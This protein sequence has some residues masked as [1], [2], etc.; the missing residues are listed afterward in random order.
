[1]SLL[2]LADFELPSMAGLPGIADASRSTRRAACESEAAPAECRCERALQLQAS[3][4]TVLRHTHTISQKLRSLQAASPETDVATTQ[5]A[6]LDLP[7][8]V[9]ARISS[10]ETVALQQ[11]VRDLTAELLVERLH[12]KRANSLNQHLHELWWT[13][14]SA[15]GR[16]GSAVEPP[17]AL[18]D[19]LGRD[20]EFYRDAALQA[21]S[22]Q[23]AA[24]SRSRHLCA[25]IQALSDELART[26]AGSAAADALELSARTSRSVAM[27][28]TQSPREIFSRARVGRAAAGLRSDG[29][30][31][32]TLSSASS[33]DFLAPVSP[34]R[35]PLESP[36]HPRAKQ[37]PPRDGRSTEKVRNPAAPFGPAAELSSA[38]CIRGSVAAASSPS[39][40]VPR[41]RAELLMLSAE[42]ATAQ[43]R[44][45]ELAQQLESASHVV[46]LLAPR[47]FYYVGDAAVDINKPASQAA[48]PG[49]AFAID[50]RV[51]EDATARGLRVPLDGGGDGLKRS[52]AKDLLGGGRAAGAGL[53]PV[54][55]LHHIVRD[56]RMQIAAQA[57]Q[58]QAT[59]VTLQRARAVVLRK[60]LRRIF[61]RSADCSR[62]AVIAAEVDGASDTASLSPAALGAMGSPCVD[63][64]T[65]GALR[66]ALE[67]WRAAAF[68]RAVE[69][70]TARAASA[71]TAA[72][73]QLLLQRSLLRW[74]YA[75]RRRQQAVRLLGRRLH[76]R[77]L[78]LAWQVWKGRT[79]DAAERATELDNGECVT[80]LTATRG[81][82]Y[83]AL[84]AA[85][86]DLP[87]EPCWTRGD[88][89]SEPVAGSPRVHP[90]RPL[91]IGERKPHLSV[92]PSRA[93][94][95][96][97]L[98]ASLQAQAGLRLQVEAATAETSR[99][100]A[101]LQ[102]TDAAV[103][104]SAAALALLQA[105]VG[106]LQ[107]QLRDSK[108]QTRMA[109]RRARDMRRAVSAA[110]AAYR[111]GV[112]QLLSSDLREEGAD[113]EGAD[114]GAAVR[115]SL[116]TP[117]AEIPEDSAGEES[118]VD[119]AESEAE[120]L[121]AAPAAAAPPA[122]QTLLSQWT[123][124]R[125]GGRAETATH[126][127]QAAD[128]ALDQAQALPGHLDLL[129]A[130]A[131]HFSSLA[132]RADLERAAA[133]AEA[134]ALAAELEGL[135]EEMR[136]RSAVA[137]EAEAS[138]DSA[139]RRRLAVEQRLAASQAARAE[140]AQEL[141]RSE[142]GAAALQLRCDQL[143]EEVEQGKRAVL[144]LGLQLER[145]LWALAATEQA[146]KHAQ[147]ATQLGGKDASRV[148]GR[149][150]EVPQGSS[151]LD[152]APLGPSGTAGGLR[153]DEAA[154]TGRSGATRE[155][156]ASSALILPALPAV[157]PL[158]ADA[159]GARAIGLAALSDSESEGGRD[160]GT[161]PEAV[162]GTAPATAARARGKHE[163]SERD[164]PLEAGPLHLQPTAAADTATSNAT[165][166]DR[167]EAPAG[168]QAT[169]NAP[170]AEGG[171]H[172]NPQTDPA[173]TVAEF[174]LTRGVASGDPP[175]SATAAEHAAIAM[176]APSAGINP[177]ES[178]SV[179]AQW[180]SRAIVGQ[181]RLAETQS[182]LQEAQREKSRAAHAL[183]ELRRQLNEARAALTAAGRQ[184]QPPTPVNS[185]VRGPP[186]AVTAG[187]A[188][189]DSVSSLS[190][191]MAPLPPDAVRSPSAL[192]SLAGQQSAG[193][194]IRS[195]GSRDAT[196]RGYGLA[197]A[198]PCT[199]GGDAADD[200]SGL[201]LGMLLTPAILL[202]ATL[203]ES[204]DAALTLS[205]GTAG[206]AMAEAAR[207][208]IPSVR[209]HNTRLSLV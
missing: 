23:A 12:S 59:N 158:D 160:A 114:I 204:P 65:Q 129:S 192:L 85:P 111:R 150:I 191:A 20:A 56:N 24:E 133:Q 202:R 196:Q 67:R 189:V 90:S 92:V 148:A 185:L 152:D 49:A 55:A 74:V 193:P 9:T 107:A 125:D 127:M 170:G 89:V 130:A 82:G 30:P 80:P 36:A 41:L 105:E 96:L 86:G 123:G 188:A 182:R 186:D 194:V 163:R 187:N 199:W 8:A 34:R 10:T 57:V 115:N 102:A 144:K 48:G 128:G 120:R 47:L 155:M 95:Q 124:V 161:A 88:Q 207:P 140:L 1:M 143:S 97:A 169:L 184:Q 73:R 100:A 159:L 153:R 139:E 75:A 35:T 103:Q 122:A 197:V 110:S 43:A 156:D 142:A 138:G 134:A 171:L 208:P 154:T 206:P 15:P 108:R 6:A 168:P 174:A 51:G 175:G 29:V 91:S 176:A 19:E 98:H 44:C 18:F 39:L 71:K 78:A 205:A 26:A 198:S 180:R 21:V 151:R 64:S 38:L 60:L 22:E 101:A 72:E 157:V 42:L 118:C 16:L 141:R 173:S 53:A 203:A 106:T 77:R 104:G 7:N 28:R 81:D 5:G 147:L 99:I 83:P 200:D 113:G 137:G 25:L 2:A 149:G 61:F 52:G 37:L 40:E 62:P 165:A 181:W 79:D 131:A 87:S 132:T 164:D 178:Q 94:L 121:H 167:F 172:G 46:Q 54:D 162:V 209:A 45:G 112:V 195:A 183:V 4:K 3:L 166:L 145:A 17:A 13:Q 14:C 201:Q 32:I 190:V 177:S 31:T 93:R 70:R 126:A 117:L 116:A 109:R 66:Q 69:A 179:L 84:S 136:I 68:S 63:P 76:S 146:K 50:P 27:E 58:L 119:E 11:Q 135:R 33:G